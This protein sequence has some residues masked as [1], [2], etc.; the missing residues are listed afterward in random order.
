MRFKGLDRMA[1][2]LDLA[3]PPAAAS[4]RTIL[5]NFGKKKAPA[6]RGLSITAGIAD[7]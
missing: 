6:N 2:F 4:E 5:M 7:G 1:G 3:D